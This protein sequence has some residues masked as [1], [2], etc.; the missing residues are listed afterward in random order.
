MCSR[1]SEGYYGNPLVPGETCKPCECH[2]NIDPSV[3][4]SCDKDTGDCLR[5]AYHT[6]GRNCQR[7]EAGY[8][9]TA[10]NGDCTGKCIIKWV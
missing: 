3:I 4:G 2:G 10:E 5:C 9:G 1:C 7:C 6:E 8:Y